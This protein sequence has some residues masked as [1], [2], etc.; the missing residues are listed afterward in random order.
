MGAFSAESASR[1]RSAGSFDAA[2][3]RSFAKLPQGDR[4]VLELV[5]G[6]GLSY[7]EAALVLGLPP[8]VVV[9][10]VAHGRRCIRFRAVLTIEGNVAEVGAALPSASAPAPA[11]CRRVDA[12]LP[13]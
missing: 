2:I 10:A 5:G 6:T 11:R 3:E 1:R 4:R 13:A 9:R 8:S 12:V 7:A